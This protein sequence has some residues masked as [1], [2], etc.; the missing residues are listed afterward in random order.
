MNIRLFLDKAAKAAFIIAAG[1]IVSSCTDQ[2]LSGN[3]PL[4]SD[5]RIAF[6]VSIEEGWRPGS[7]SSENDPE[8][9][10]HVSHDKKMTKGYKADDESAENPLYIFESV[11]DHIE[12]TGTPGAQHP[13]RGDMVKTDA[14]FQNTTIGVYAYNTGHPEQPFFMENVPYAYMKQMELWSSK[15]DEYLWPIYNNDENKLQFFAYSPYNPDN[16][17]KQGYPSIKVNKNNGDITI[18]HTVAELMDDQRDL[19]ISDLTDIKDINSVELTGANL[20]FHH[21]LTSVRFYCSSGSMFSGKVK[22]IKL[23]NIKGEGDFDVSSGKWDTDKYAL[24]DFSFKCDV[25]IGINDTGE[26]LDDKVSFQGDLLGDSGKTLMLLPQ[27]LRAN[28]GTESAPRLEITFEDQLTKTERVFKAELSVNWEAGQSICYNISDTPMYSDYTFEVTVKGGTVKER[29]GIVK[30][31][32]SD[33]TGREI[34]FCGNHRMP[35]ENQPELTVHSICTVYQY[36]GDKQNVVKIG[37]APATWD[38]K[39]EVNNGD[40]KGFV[41]GGETK[42]IDSGKTLELLKGGDKKGIDPETK[43]VPIVAD[44]INIH[45][46]DGKGIDMLTDASE[47]TIIDPQDKSFYDLSTCGG[48]EQRTTANCYIVSSAGSYKIPLVYGNAIKNGTDNTAAYTYI[49]GGETKHFL[50]HDDKDIMSPW[51]KDNINT[52]GKWKAEIERFQSIAA[53]A[54]Y[55]ENSGENIFENI[56]VDDNKEYLTFKISKNISTS[57]DGSR[58]YPCN[59]VIALKDENNNI[60]WTWHMWV[61]NLVSNRYPS[62]DN[63]EY[64]FDT[65]KYRMMKYSLGEL[66]PNYTTIEGREVKIE[67]TQYRHNQ[68][69]TGHV[70][71]Q[72]NQE[73]YKI[74]DFNQAL[75]YQYG[76]MAPLMAYLFRKEIGQ[77]GKTFVQGH[78][79]IFLSARHANDKDDDMEVVGKNSIGYV[80]RNPLKIFNTGDKGGKVYDKDYD[81]LWNNGTA[82]H[83]VKT[84]YDPCPRGYM[85]LPSRSG[86]NNLF[87]GK[88]KFVYDNRDDDSGDATL[89]DNYYVSYN[90]GAIKIPRSETIVYDKG[91]ISHNRRYTSFWTG[92]WV[93]SKEKPG[94]VCFTFKKKDDTLDA[95]EL[96]FRAGNGGKNDE[97]EEKDSY[98]P[99]FLLP[100]RAVIEP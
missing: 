26:H 1:T 48:A 32:E 37:T 73:G 84:V 82:D 68:S 78:R 56:K 28:A 49:S 9:T 61:T 70:V 14:D 53:M 21:A 62:L 54:S 16:S 89:Y 55:K 63:L 42:W 76:R 93:T 27:D 60:L 51:I 31:T 69:K 97:V 22:N 4:F 47:P 3:R 24:K 33:P 85:V 94:T 50:R 91:K 66:N 39:F 25:T 79:K 95:P 8:K 57:T 77:D 65:G 58:I 46:V 59:A 45:G 34:Y 12:T 80:L 20:N 40:G 81:N 29:S 98:H 36:A 86:W 75:Y 74:K 2:D 5:N 67:L 71:V 10:A 23:C 18:H 52:P 41:T 19:L 11:S 30:A 83:P 15:G 43:I 44:S 96:D 92:E 17:G 13:T 88:V 35:A 90:D 7:R 72:F 64:T 87:L 38:S 100:I 6:N 99:S